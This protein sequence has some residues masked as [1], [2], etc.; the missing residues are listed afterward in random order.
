VDTYKKFAV[1]CEDMLFQIVEKDTVV[2]DFGLDVVVDVTYNDALNSQVL[3]VMNDQPDV[4]IDV[5]TYGQRQSS[6]API[7]LGVIIDGNQVNVGIAYADS[8]NSVRVSLDKNTGMLV[9]DPLLF[10]YESE[11]SYYSEQTLNTTIMYS[12]VTVIPATTIYYEDEYVTLSSESKATGS[13]TAVEGSGWDA[14]SKAATDI[15][16]NDR[17]GEN[18]VS[19]LYDADNL[20]GYDPAYSE[21]S[22]YSMGNAAKFTAS[23]TMRGVASFEFYGTG[24]DVIAAT[25]NTGNSCNCPTALNFGCC[26][27]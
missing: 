14:E 16:S 19:E 24:F 9:K 13:W 26:T 4:E 2:I 7:N 17:P 21:C 8:Q 22:T 12:S 5:G 25:S 1:A 20:Y 6:N 18:K 11:V 10:Y 23:R 3:G 27:I 15:Q